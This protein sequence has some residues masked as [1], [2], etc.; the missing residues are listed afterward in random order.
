MARSGQYNE[1]HLIMITFHT[2]QVYERR[3]S[4]T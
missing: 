4:P 2:A 3:I 1:L